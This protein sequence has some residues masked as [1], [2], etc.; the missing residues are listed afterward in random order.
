MVVLS[1]CSSVSISYAGYLGG[2]I[3][4]TELSSTTISKGA[5]EGGQGEGG[6]KDE[7]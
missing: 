7:D 4:H 5:N 6:E 3:R 2:K 1:L